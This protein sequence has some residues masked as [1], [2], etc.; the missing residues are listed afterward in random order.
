MSWLKWFSKSITR[1]TSTL[2]VLI[3]TMSSLFLLFYFYQTQTTE[4]KQITK[5]MAEQL[6]SSLASTNAQHVHFENHYL[7]WIEVKSQ[8]KNNEQQIKK[9]SLFKITEIV[10]LDLN[11]DVFSHSSPIN[12]PLKQKYTGQRLDG[13]M[14][15]NELDSLTFT[16]IQ[17]NGVEAIRLYDKLVYQDRIVGTIILQL[18]L[19]IFQL[20]QDGLAKNFLVYLLFVIV[21]AMITGLVFGQ[22][23]S[24]PMVLIKASLKNMGSGKVNL[25][26]LHHR[27]DEYKT[28]AKLIEET[29]KNLFISQSRITLLLDSTAE[30][31]YGLNMNG[32]CTFCNLACLSMLGYKKTSELLSQNMHTLIH[33]SYADGSPYPVTDCLIYKSFS[34]G[35]KVHIDNEV[36]FRKDGSSFAAE[37]WSHPIIVDELIIGSVVTFLDITD[38]KRA[39]KKLSHQASHDALTGLINRFE[40]ERRANWLFSIKED[41]E[42]HAMCF[43]DLD[44]F[45][46]V[47]D[48]CGH[49]AGDELLRQISMLLQSKVR[50]SDF[51][52]RLGGD[53]FGLLMEHCSLDRARKI[54]ESLLK[55][56][57]NY[58]F[59]W[60]GNTFK[61]GVSI[62]LV[63]ITK[64]IN[65][66]TE[67]LKQVDAACYIAKDEGRNRVHVYNA[68]DA[69]TALRQGEMQWVPQIH[70]A[71][72]ENRFC[73]YAQ[74]IMSLK[75]PRHKHYEL[76]IRMISK[77]G[78]VIP[79]GAFLP[80]AERYNLATLL[81]RWVIENAFKMLAAHPE[82]QQ[83]ISFISLNLSGQSL[84]DEKFI[85]FVIT[86]LK[87]T[88][89]DGK[90]ICFEITETAAISNLSRAIKF[91]STLSGLGCK[92]AL[93]DFG[94]G[95]SSY[96]YLKNL[97][98]DYLKI[99]GMFVKGIVDSPVDRAMVKSIN[100]IAHV[101]DMETIAE[102]VENDAIMEMLRNMGV[103]Y[104]QGYTID[105][106][107]PFGEVLNQTSEVQVQV[108]NAATNEK[109]NGDVELPRRKKT[110]N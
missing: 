63:V 18:D 17:A 110:M 83:Q 49:V 95:L 99:D 14:P 58:Q 41:D 38:R 62:G 25:S 47:N 94:S 9:G 84:A 109:E 31:I 98:V 60:E 11:G 33:H 88:N 105:K 64:A 45:K 78:T 20:Y 61:I 44:Q 79:P 104:G 53:E 71:L 15:I 70:Q 21:A 35:I 68:D 97:P 82:F 46:V 89:I 59:V 1:Q 65:N 28:L 74:S 92:F 67:L 6:I 37:Y 100:D 108:Q 102:F 40:F 36:L 24:S 57:Q 93:D 72:E 22:W 85:D 42:E 23:V 69:D 10:L 87:N 3:L 8:L 54:A 2:L 81:D 12:H 51:L 4:I 101:M 32:I 29:D 13:P 43:L 5:Q 39:D 96:G 50:K 103:N 16:W 77:E 73:L 52:A 26:Q 48:N 19:S 90:I 27:A 80:A 55:E 76:L 30:A 56:I 86:Q 91:I 107:T 7:A 34:T 106:P 75:G 66:V